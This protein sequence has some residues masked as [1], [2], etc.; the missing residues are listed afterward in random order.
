[1]TDRAV[2][3]PPDVRQCWG[4]VLSGPAW[5]SPWHCT[6]RARHGYLTCF[7][8]AAR[9]DAARALFRQLHNPESNHDSSHHRES[10]GARGDS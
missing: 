10:G 6:K 2:E 1:M 7:F 8:H 3:K 5:G 4:L 9:E